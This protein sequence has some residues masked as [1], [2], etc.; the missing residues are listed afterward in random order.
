M[1]SPDVGTVA[2]E[3]FHQLKFSQLLSSFANRETWG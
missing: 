2:F 3:T 1:S